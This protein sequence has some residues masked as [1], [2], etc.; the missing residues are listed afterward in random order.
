MAQNNSRIKLLLREA[1]TNWHVASGILD[2]CI[3][4]KPRKNGLEVGI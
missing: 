2:A 4:F 3:F 1:E